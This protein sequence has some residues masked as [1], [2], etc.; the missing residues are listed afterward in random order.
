[1]SSRVLIVANKWW[2]ATPLLAVIEHADARSAGITDAASSAELCASGPTPRLTFRC[3]GVLNEIWCLQD[4]M[5]PDLSAS[6]TWEK[7]RVLKRVLRGRTANLVI[8]FGTAACIQG[9]GFNGNVV[10]GSSVF[11]HDPYAQPPDPAHHWTHQN[12]DKIITST[13]SA[14]PNAISEGA[15]AEA[16]KRML[17]PPNQ[18]AEFPSIDVSP[19]LVSVGVVNVT[20]SKDYEWTDAQALKRFGETASPT[21]NALSMETTHGV[22]RIVLDQPFLYFSGFANG[23]GKYA[24]EVGAN[25]YAQNFAAAHNAAVAVAWLLPDIVK[26]L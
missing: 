10:V 2:E 16:R 13:A 21:Q 25:K 24:A 15:L 3:N 11:V 12:L 5:D 1:M 26:A 8:G 9:S 23:I 17:R 4:L 18:A 14:L 19:D 22:I 20:T 6:L 7:A